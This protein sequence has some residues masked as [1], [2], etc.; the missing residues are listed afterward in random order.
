MKTY[1]LM[2]SRQ[3][4]FRKHQQKALRK[5]TIKRH[6]YQLLVRLYLFQISEIY[7]PK[8]LQHLSLMRCSWQLQVQQKTKIYLEYWVQTLLLQTTSCHQQEAVKALKDPLCL[9][10]FGLVTKQLLYVLPR[11]ST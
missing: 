10:Q 7:R 4:L 9:V 6:Q 2:P 8:E 5:Y 3:S 11:L 1:C